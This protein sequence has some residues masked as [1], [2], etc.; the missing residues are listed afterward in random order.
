MSTSM[1]CKATDL[2]ALLEEMKRDVFNAS[3]NPT[4][5]SYWIAAVENGE[6]LA[7]QLQAWQDSPEFSETE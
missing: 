7:E 4:D 6:K 2:I 3:F 5:A 1:E